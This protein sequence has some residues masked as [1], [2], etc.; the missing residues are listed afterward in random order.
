[1]FDEKILNQLF[2]MKAQTDL[3]VIDVDTYNDFPGQRVALSMH[4][5]DN[6]GEYHTHNFYEIN[7]V[8]RGG[9]INLVE[10][11]PLVMREG[12]FVLLHP[13]VFHTLYASGDSVIIN[14]LIRK[15]WLEG[16]LCNYNLPDSPLADFIRRTGSKKYLRYLICTHNISDSFSLALRMFEANS[17]DN[18]KKYL[19]IEALMIEFMSSLLFEENHLALSESTGKTSEISRKLLNYVTNNYSEV[20]LQ[21]ISEHT[22]YSKTHICRLFRTDTGKSFGETV[23]DIRLS[24]AKYALINT[25]APIKNIAY[26][27]G[28][29]SIEHFQRLFKRKTGYTPGEYRKSFGISSGSAK[30]VG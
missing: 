23:T 11:T 25:D 4:C 17:G 24:H 12:E 28:F 6:V 8:L 14:F 21:S 5:N 9:C 19:T 10:E 22:G 18:I 7:F 1:M 2:M 13:G 16:L 26:A 30:N 27:I 20:T 15:D 29:Q 3:G